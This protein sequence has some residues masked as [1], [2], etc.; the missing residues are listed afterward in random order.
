MDSLRFQRLWTRTRGWFPLAG[1]VLV[2]SAFTIVLPGTSRM[3]QAYA[4]YLL[5]ELM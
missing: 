4:K 2:I 5:N 3:E 1:P